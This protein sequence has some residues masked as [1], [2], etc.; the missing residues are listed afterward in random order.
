MKIPSFKVD[1]TEDDIDFI[2]NNFKDILRGKTFLSQYKHCEEFEKKFAEY[3]GT[4]YAASVTNGTCAL[5]IILRILDFKGKEVIVPTNTSAATAFAVIH[6][7]GIPVFADCGDDLTL[8][9]EDVRKRITDKTKAIMTVHI[10]GLISPSTQELMEICKDNDLYFV[11]DAAQAHGSTLDNR[12]AGTFGIANGF[13]FFSTKVMTTGEGGMIT[14]NNEDIY[15]KTLILRNQAKI[16]KG[17][18]QNYH[19]E[20]GNNWRMLEVV[21]LLGL[22]Q[23]RRLEDFIKRRNEI[24]KI[25]NEEFS[26]FDKLSILNISHNVRTNYYKYVLFLNGFDREKLHKE[27]K[28][29]YNIAMGGYVFEIPLHMIPA[30]KNFVRARLPKSEKLCAT[31]ICP[32]IFFRM[33]DEEALYV[34]KSI[35]E[36]L[37]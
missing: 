33:T 8:D 2:T 6:A 19:E 5:E 32:P 21:A 4:K 13:S 22:R 9:P 37:K 25:Y 14:T 31:H 26:N 1:F 36:C 30:F 10:G 29:K 17:I 11:E 28:E 24:A 35:K 12:K 23:L 16:W 34:A 3:I 18:Y 20:I 7:G 15:N 27:L